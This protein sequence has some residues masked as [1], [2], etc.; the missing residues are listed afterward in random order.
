VASN[1]F[2]WSQKKDNLMTNGSSHKTIKA[3]NSKP[4]KPATTTKPDAK[5]KT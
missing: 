3:D 2:V 5:K 1:S 4:A